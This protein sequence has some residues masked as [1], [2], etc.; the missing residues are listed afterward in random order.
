MY[1]VK[2]FYFRYIVMRHHS[3]KARITKRYISLVWWYKPRPSERSESWRAGVRGRGPNKWA[4]RAPSQCWWV[5]ELVSN[6]WAKMAYFVFWQKIK[7]PRPLVSLILRQYKWVK[8]ATN[9]GLSSQCGAAAGHRTRDRE[10]RVRNSL[11][12]SGFPLGKKICWHC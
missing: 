7:G 4:S 8:Q 12:P 5:G 11:V 10:V 6:W 1:N 9:L 2:A 3:C